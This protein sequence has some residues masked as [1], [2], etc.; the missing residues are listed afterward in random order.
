MK[1]VVAPDSFKGSL[2][3]VAAAGS[4]EAGIKKVCSDIDIVKIP[5]A[6]GGEGMV[7]ALVCAAG[8]SIVKA[9]VHGP[10]MEPVESFFGILAGGKTAVIEM[11]AA[12][13]LGMVPAGRL[14]PMETTTYGV[15]ELIAAA[16]DA[17]CTGIIVGIGGSATNDGGIGMAQALGA[18]F[19]DKDGQVL[20]HGG[21]Y[22][23]EAASIDV[24]GLDK[25]LKGMDIIAACDVNNPLCGPNGASYVFG[26]QKGA[27]PSMV[28]RLDAGLRRYAQVIEKELCIDIA[29]IPGS[30]AAGGLGGGLIA[31]A[32]AVLRPGIDIMMDICRFEDAIKDADLL[33]TGEGMTD[34]QTACGKAPAGL[35]A[36]AKKHGV[37]VVCL[38]GSLGMGFEAVYEAG[39]DAALSI[40]GKP[41]LLEEA[42]ADAGRMLEASAGAV[43]RLFLA[44][45]GRGKNKC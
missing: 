40:I 41:M 3:S 30:G 18:R 39:I 15:G 9:G 2:S 36:A 28:E 1:I 7:E 45:A 16:M 5:V 13:G 10:L 34:Y 32:G 12:S 6:D 38:S 29:D 31:F 22:A 43:A 20:G 44:L 33:M 14:D 21:R 42:M 26:P 19:Y 27:T 35:A 23:G 25:R 24:S 8:G 37:P 11:A 17:G 4:M